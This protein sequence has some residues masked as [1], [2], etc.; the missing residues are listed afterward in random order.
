MGANSWIKP[1]RLASTVKKTEDPKRDTRLLR[2]LRGLSRAVVPSMF[3]LKIDDGMGGTWQPRVLAGNPQ[4]AVALEAT[5]ENFLQLWRLAQ[6]SAAGEDSGSPV[7]KRR[8]SVDDRPAPVQALPPQQNVA[9]FPFLLLLLLPRVLLR[10]S[11]ILLFLVP[12]C[13]VVVVRLR[14]T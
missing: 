1:L 2:R 10:A 3:S 8:R 12:V 11:H 9:P 14:T 13:F 7:A 4:D 5:T 6:S